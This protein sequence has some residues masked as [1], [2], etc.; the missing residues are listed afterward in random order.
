LIFSNK[1]KYLIVANNFFQRY[2]LIHEFWLTLRNYFFKEIFCKVMFFHPID[3][4]FVKI[5]KMIFFNF[6]ISMQ[7]I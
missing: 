2:F 7:F 5:K 6:Q 1:I 4:S 3:N